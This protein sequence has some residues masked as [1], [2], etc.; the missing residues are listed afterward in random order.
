MISIVMPTFNQA[1][2]IGEAI[3]S[4]LRQTDRNY[5]LIIIN[6]YSEDGTEEIVRSYSDPRIHYYKFNN[7]GI[8]AA[9]RNYG[10]RLSKGKYIA[11]LDSDDIWLPKKLEKQVQMMEENP[12]IALSYVLFGR[13]LQDGTVKGIYPYHSRRKRGF[14]YEDLYLLNV[15]AN[16]GAMVRAS[17]FNRIGLLDEDPNLVGVED[18]DMWLRISRDNQVDYVKSDLLLLYRVRD[19]NVFYKKAIEKIQRRLYLAKKFYPDIGVIGFFKKI[20]L[21]P[22]C[23]LLKA[24]VAEHFEVS[25]QTIEYI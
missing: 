19:N 22:V 20:I 24:L 7:H 1:S 16:S 18:A 13:L 8:I 11:F 23:C 25:N 6:N 9:S 21:I 15:I 4:V 3:D 17:I 10:I 2:F 5:E 12:E 14:I